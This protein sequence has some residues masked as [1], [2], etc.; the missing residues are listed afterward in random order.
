MQTRQL[1]RVSRMALS[2]SR[3][4]ENNAALKRENE[5]L[6]STSHAL[7]AYV[8]RFLGTVWSAIHEEPKEKWP[9]I[10]GRLYADHFQGALLPLLPVRRPLSGCAAAPAA[11]RQGAL[12][13]LLP[14][15]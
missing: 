15:V 9:A 2:K 7:K 8:G 4:Q 14:F 13:P 12:L 10:F 3:T 6:R 11:R 1:R 5:R